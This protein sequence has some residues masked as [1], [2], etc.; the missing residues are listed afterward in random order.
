MFDTIYGEMNMDESL[1]ENK[2]AGAPSG[3]NVGLGLIVDI[4]EIERVLRY[5]KTINKADLDE[6]VWMRGTMG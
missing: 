5:F 1:S 4:M 2:A 3:L 6:I